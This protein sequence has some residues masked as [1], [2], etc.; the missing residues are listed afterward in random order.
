M[1]RRDT[2]KAAPSLRRT[3]AQGHKPMRASS[4]SMCSMNPRPRPRGKRGERCAALAAKMRVPTLSKARVT[5]NHLRKVGR[6]WPSLGQG[7]S[8]LQSPTSFIPT[9]DATSQAGPEAGLPTPRAPSA[10]PRDFPGELQ[11]TIPRPSSCL[12]A[13]AG[14]CR[15]I[16]AHSLA[17]EAWPT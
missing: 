10:T 16:S 8:V 9:S 7:T 6:K 4:T 13:P 11:I 2:G 15:G 12:A 14:H 17:I 5:S 3:L 1:P